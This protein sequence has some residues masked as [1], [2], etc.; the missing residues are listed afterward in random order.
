MRILC[1]NN[2]PLAKMHALADAGRMPRQH[3]WGTDALMRRAEVVLAPFQDAEEQRLL[4][5]TSA[6]LRHRLG[7]LDQQRLALTRPPYDVLFSGD[8][9]SLRGIAAARPL[10]ARSSRLVSVLHHPEPRGGP[11][12]RALRGHTRLLALSEQLRRLAIERHGVDPARAHVA[13]WGPDLRFAGYA[14]TGEQHGVV[15]AGKSNRDL[16]TLVGALADTGLRATVY[17]TRSAVADAPPAVTLVRPGGPGSDPSSP[18]AYLFAP[19]IEHL[20]GAS[21]VAIPAADPHRLTGLTEVDDALALA[22]PIVITR[23]PYMPVD[24]EAVGC[25]IA[26][27]PG[28]RAGWARALERLDADPDLRRAMGRRGRA[29]A[30]AG[31]NYDAFCDAV[32]A[33]V[34]ADG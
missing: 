13:P 20:R 9:Q 21:V 6:L 11:V 8:G 7:Q 12:G 22:K 2:Y 30:E 25:G 34:E 18:G 15:S 33:A 4:A 29:F 5:R 23:S 26:V 1:L 31:F 32:V 24:V 28:D 16:T 19:V 17:D 3:L 27:D 14:S 10:L